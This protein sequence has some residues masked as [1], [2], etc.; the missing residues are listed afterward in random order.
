M[1]TA[2]TGTL[3]DCPVGPDSLP[4][5]KRQQTNP[6]R[7]HG[8]NWTFVAWGGLHGSFLVV[9]HAWR[10]A[11][12]R[13]G[14]ATPFPGGRLAGAALTFAAVYRAPV[15]LCVVNNQWAISSFQ[16]IAGGE[17][18]TFAARGVGNGIASLRVDGNDFLAVYAATQWAAER[19]RKGAG[20]TL[21]EFTVVAAA[22]TVYA[23]DATGAG[24]A[25]VNTAQQLLKLDNLREDWHR[26][27]MEAYAQLGKRA[28][29]LEQYERC[30]QALR[31]IRTGRS[32]ERMCSIRSPTACWPWRQRTSTARP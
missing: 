14:L 19:A 28:T 29:A 13:L 17:A 26:A 2:P 16:F 25:V 4:H 27:L 1:D 5:I 18:T 23:G 15:I 32:T 30:R 21:M 8:A 10:A 11:R 3:G 31:S 20:A 9:H 24:S 6:A 7:W 12:G 22:V